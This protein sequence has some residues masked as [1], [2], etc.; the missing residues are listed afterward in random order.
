MPNEVVIGINKNNSHI[1]RYVMYCLRHKTNGYSLQNNIKIESARI[2]N[3]IFK[4]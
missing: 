1:I 2:R 4:S 3:S